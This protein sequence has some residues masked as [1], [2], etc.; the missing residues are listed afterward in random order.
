ML[1]KTSAA[2]L[3]LG[4]LFI[5]GCST[6]IHRVGDGAQGKSMIEA[7][8]WYVLFGLVP[9]NQVDTAT[10]AGDATDYEIMTQANV[11]DIV[12]GI[13]TGGLSISTRTVTVRK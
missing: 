10:M 13:L 4:I 1:R 12:I 8:Q 11:V 7:R 5:V 6:H 9:I 2:I 3:I